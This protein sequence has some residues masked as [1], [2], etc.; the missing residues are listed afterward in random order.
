M[1][2]RFSVLSAA[3][4]ISILVLV[5]CNG[6]S[7]GDD[8][9]AL[10]LANLQGTFDLDVDASGFTL[11]CDNDEDVSAV[12]V[13]MEEKTAPFTGTCVDGTVETRTATFTII[14]ENTVILT[15]NGGTE[16]VTVTLTNGG[17]RLT[18]IIKAN[19][20]TLIFN[21]R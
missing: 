8:P 6:N 13:V 7:D 18:I 3:L 1:K 4:L 20:N 15:D 11:S 9:N 5:G 2:A 10:T 12:V 21:K 16:D 17:T 19:G 14:D